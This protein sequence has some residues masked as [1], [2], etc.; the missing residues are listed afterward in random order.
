MSFVLF[1]FIGIGFLSFLGFEYSSVGSVI[2]FFAIYFL[3]GSPIDFLCTS[4]LDV[5]RY[6]NRLPYTI[7]KIIESLLDITLTF[8]TMA[9]IDV[10]MNSISIPI[11]TEILFAILSYL[12]SQCVDFFDKDTNYEN[13][14]SNNHDENDINK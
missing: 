11:H 13:R 2:L 5:F 8:I 6:V 3:I 14:N 7:Y 10:F 4:L 1:T 12:L 9:I